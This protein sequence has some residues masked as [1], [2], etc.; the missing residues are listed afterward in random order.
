MYAYIAQKEN[1]S[2]RFP[3]SELMRRRQSALIMLSGGL[4][5][6]VALYWAMCKK[7]RIEAIT[8]DHFHRSQRERSAAFR[9]AKLT[10]IIQHRIDI[11]FLKEIED[12]REMG[13]N[14]DLQGAPSAYVSS[15]NV[16]FYGIASSIAEMIGARYIVGGHNKDDVES[17]PDASRAFFDQ[18]NR[19]TAIGL[20]TGSKTGRV[21]LP[22]SKLSK[23]QIV[24]LGDRLGVPFHITWSCYQS[25]KRP[26]GKCH[27]CR[28]RATAFREAGMSDPLAR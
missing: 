10:K 1:D 15:R 3:L 28:L 24:R 16:I 11:N 6:A 23:I 20:Y 7:Y 12:S 2:R 18:F 8:F 26:C 9:L 14:P 5:S 19:T 4:D 17:F 13:R 25:G 21:I 22:L 27:S